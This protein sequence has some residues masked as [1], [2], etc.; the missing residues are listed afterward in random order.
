MFSLNK[1]SSIK[2]NLSTATGFFISGFLLWLL[3]KQSQVELKQVYDII[4]PPGNALLFSCAMALF[5]C[6]VYM[7]SLRT[8]TIFVDKNKTS[9]KISALPSLAIGNLYNCL[10]L[11]NLGEGVRALHFSRVNNISFASTFA[12]F[13]LEKIVDAFL[14]I[15]LFITLLIIFP[16]K[17]HLLQYA[18]LL[19]LLAILIFTF[20]LV[21]LSKSDKIT[22][23]IFNLVPQKK[24]KVFLFKVYK[25]GTNHFKR[26]TKNKT[27]IWFSFLSYS[28]FF[29]NIL[30]YYIILNMVNVP[31]PVLSFS[32]AFLLSLSMIIIAFIPS[33]PG[34][35]G[36]AH[37]GIFASLMMVTTVLEISYTAHHL[38]QFAL[39]GICMHASYFIPEVLIGIYFMLREYKI[40]FR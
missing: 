22:K 29:A 10:L 16:F 6:T 32:T 21:I 11:G 30:Q 9:H 18:V 20:A 37:Y 12:I 24:L 33:A 7:H 31:E 39:V 25:Y 35:I 36:V 27:I 15:P 26:M 17:H 3:V 40:I 13:F 8:Q 34:N 28:M 5:V 4:S 23:G 1:F 14:S 2:K 19:V 38:K